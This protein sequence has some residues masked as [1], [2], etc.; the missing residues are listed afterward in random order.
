MEINMK[1]KHYI[2][3]PTL[4]HENRLPPR[5]LLI[6]AQQKGITHRNSIIFPTAQY[7]M[8]N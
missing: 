2:E 1:L 8:P 4:L 6:P 5:S 7:P 3:N